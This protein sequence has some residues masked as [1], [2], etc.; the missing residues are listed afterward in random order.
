[1]KC[2]INASMSRLSW[3][4][5][6]SVT[7]IAVV[8]YAPVSN[9]VAP[10]A[11][12][13]RLRVNAIDCR[14]PVS[15]SSANLAHV[16]QARTNTNF[17]KANI[18]GQVRAH[19][20]QAAPAQKIHGYRCSRRES[21]LQFVCG[22]HSHTKIAA[23]P[24]VLLPREVSAVECFNWSTQW[25]ITLGDN[26]SQ[27]ISPNQRLRH[28]Y[29]RDGSLTRS[30]TNAWCSGGTGRVDGLKNDYLVTLVQEEY[31]VE[32]V[33]LLAGATV[34]KD[35]SSNTN[36]PSECHGKDTCLAPPYSYR[37]I[38]PK[39][40][41]PFHF[42]TSVMMTQVPISVQNKVQRA[43]ISDSIKT[44]LI[45]KGDELAPAACQG[46]FR[47]YTNTHYPRIKAIIVAKDAPPLTAEKLGLVSTPDMVSP[48]QQ[49]RSTSEYLSFTFEK[50]LNLADD[51]VSRRFCELSK[52]QLRDA[53]LSPFTQ[54]AL[55]R[56]R[57][58]VIQEI[59]CTPVIAELRLGEVRDPRCATT[60]IPAWVNGYPVYMEG[61]THLVL[62]PDSVS[63][64]DCKTAFA[65]YII[66]RD[67]SILTHSPMVKRTELQLA[68]WTDKIGHQRETIDHETFDGQLLYEPSSVEAFERMLHFSRTKARV[69]DGFVSRYCSA[70]ESCGSFSPP[71]SASMFNFDTFQSYANPLN[72][73][74]DVWVTVAEYGNYAS[75]TMFLIYATQ[76]L[77]KI[78][79]CHAALGAGHT[80][81]QAILWSFIYDPTVANRPSTGHSHQG[82]PA[83]HSMPAPAIRGYHALHT[84]HLPGYEDA[85]MA[86]PMPMVPV[87]T[88][89]SRSPSR[90]PDKEP[91]SSSSNLPADSDNH[92]THRVYPNAA[93]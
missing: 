44:L 31:L 34:L 38:Y 71:S 18:K 37:M 45:T 80:P 68:T 22:M 58:D 41:C 42:V 91:R 39:S 87:H 26:T 93:V 21:T 24:E 61:G 3:A 81:A 90:D 86:H 77:L 14:Q 73:L 23:V 62:D 70:T 2:H 12:E 50:R 15:I 76:F 17:T 65:P 89:R 36:L 55:L 6:I 29:V 53:E 33:Q 84:G 64:V 74:P 72:Y 57:G 10:S 1:M 46:F 47:E 25:R 49:L 11:P 54:N 19:I 56:L 5:T 32:E 51:A 43:L 83:Y 66:G 67:G 60:A 20:I 69:L 27:S 82:G 9:A 35:L 92:R 30:N 63:L 79:K 7:L 48:E 4:V 28:R 16:C 40:R 13:E 78:W 88:S 85:T 8:S 52:D 59:A 75:I